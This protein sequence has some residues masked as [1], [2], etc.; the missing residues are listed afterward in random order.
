MWF[1][2]PEGVTE[3]NCQQQSFVAE[4][5]DDTGAYFRAPDHFAPF[6]LGVP[7]FA[8]VDAP[9]DAPLG[10]PR[11]LHENT[12]G[13]LSRQI[14]SLKEDL[15]M[16]RADVAANAL[17]LGAKGREIVELKKRVEELEEENEDLRQK[18]ADAGE[19]V[20]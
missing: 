12:I 13:D 3:V 15:S 4:V 14:S 9:R 8:A 17:D 11:F 16:A 19:P 18:L 2:F 6:L 5:E 10:E 20:E 1:K 7:G